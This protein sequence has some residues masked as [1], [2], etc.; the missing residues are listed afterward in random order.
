M[1]LPVP[2]QND[3]STVSRVPLGRWGKGETGIR[4]SVLNFRRRIEAAVV[5]HAG[6]VNEAAA[7]VIARAC[8]ALRYELRLELKVSSGELELDHWLACNDRILRA[9]EVLDKALQ[10]IGLKPGAKRSQIAAWAALIEDDADDT[11]DPEAVQGD[12]DAS[13]A[14]PGDQTQEVDDDD[15]TP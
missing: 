5:E 9:A 11:S 12:P 8:K 13:C 2:A 4:R 6:E 3:R 1:G 10:A 7:V 15:Q 14:T